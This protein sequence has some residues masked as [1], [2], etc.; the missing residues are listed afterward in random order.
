MSENKRSGAVVHIDLTPPA[1]CEMDGYSDRK[2]P[3]EGI[4]D[5]ITGQLLLLEEGDKRIALITMDL[6]GVE[7]AYSRRVRE[8]VAG[9]LDT[10]PEF[11][12]LTCSHTHSGPAGFMSKMLILQREADEG[13]QEIVCRKLVGAAMEA[14]RNLQPV[15]LSIGNGTVYGIGTNRND[16]KNG[17]FD[18]ELI[19][20]RMDEKHGE[21]LAVWMNY[22]C[23]PTVLGASNLQISA[24]YPGAARDALRQIYPQT[25]FMFSNG[26]SGDI[27]T[28]F[29]RREQTFREVTRMGRIL[30]GE[31][32]KAMQIAVPLSGSGLGGA[33]EE[34]NLPYKSFPT[35]TEAEA[36]LAQCEM[37]LE[38]LHKQKAPENELRRLFTT[39]QGARFQLELLGEFEGKSGQ[40]S[41]IQALYIGDLGLVGLPG[42]PFTQIVLDLK[43]RSEFAWTAVL[44]YANDE[45]GYFPDR[46][47]YEAG[48]YESFISPFC[49][50]IA[51]IV[52]K[53]AIHLLERVRHA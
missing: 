47:T 30:A 2:S 18:P 29:N 17:P 3:S 9:V 49:D 33:A 20:L 11:V 52:T 16:P 45:A 32:L 12:L 13:L 40:S 37:E 24:D 34:I 50:N 48:T 26:A 1:G 25:V 28:R 51:E 38:S 15:T 21:P 19:V 14:A 39:T 36:L 6:I 42:E 10:T 5:P 4:H 22:G 8:E 43:G 7:L 46:E 53:R 41:L 23:H 35:R 27:S 44:S 31:T